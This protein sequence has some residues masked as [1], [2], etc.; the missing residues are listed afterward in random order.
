VAKNLLLAEERSGFSVDKEKS[1]SGIGIWKK[2]WLILFLSLPVIPKVKIVS[3]GSVPIL[4][5]DAILSGMV[6][7]GLSH[8]L[9]RA[10]AQGSY[11]LKLSTAS[12]VLILFL[13]YKVVGLFILSLVYPWMDNQIGTGVFFSEGILVIAKFCMLVCVY[14]LVYNSIRQRSDVIT[15]IYYQILIVVVVVVVGMIQWFVL[16]HKVITAT[17]RNIYAIQTVFGDIDPWFGQTA[18]GHEH[19]GAFLVISIPFILSMLVY[20]W[21][22]GR[23]IRLSLFLLL[24]GATFCLIFAS[25]RG[26]W[27]GAVCMLTAFAGMMVKTGKLLTFSRMLMAGL[28]VFVYLQWGASIDF[29]GF[30]EGRIE[31]LFVLLVGEIRDDSAYHRIKMAKTLW[32]V[33]C[34]YPLWGL[35]AG[36]AGRIAEGQYLRELVEGGIVGFVLFCVLIYKC[37]EM[38]KPL[39]QPGTEPMGQAISIGFFCALVGILGQS[40][41]TELF[42]ITKVSVPFWIWASLAHKVAALTTIH[43]KKAII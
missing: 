40:I 5:D 14:I 38:V 26:A 8:A 28:T 30:V 19:L 37:S 12:G 3:L 25:S 11:A 13:V 22:S 20:R 9:W 16:G 43:P 4:F 34:Q 23:W 29:I 1:R 35:G 36:G 32:G 17:F 31:D 15:V 41:F 6:L 24:S 39:S 7:V 27:V 42:I 2:L 33:F 18:V 10:A 21:P